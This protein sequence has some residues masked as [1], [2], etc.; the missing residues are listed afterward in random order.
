M[1]ILRSLK[2]TG[3]MSRLLLVAFVILALAGCGIIPISK[4]PVEVPSESDSSALD[5]CPATEAQWLT[6]PDDPAVS[7]APAPNYYFVNEDR[8]IWAN[9]W[10][11]GDDEATLQAGNDGNKVGWFRPEGATLVINGKRLDKE[12]SAMEA[13][14]PCCYPTRFQAS[15][16]IFPSGGCWEVIAQAESKELRFV[17]E[18][19]P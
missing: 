10:W 7:N 8:S 18:V 4:S 12:D 5:A 6:P 16:L 11:L 19:A 14:V 9:A 17:V 13:Q 15:G 2:S 3:Y 1:L